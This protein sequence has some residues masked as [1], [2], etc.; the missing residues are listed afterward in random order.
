MEISQHLLHQLQCWPGSLISYKD[1]AY[2]LQLEFQFIPW[3]FHAW[4]IAIMFV[5]SYFFFF[6]LSKHYKTIQS[7]R[8]CF[9]S[10]W[11]ILAVHILFSSLLSS[12]MC[13]VTYEIKIGTSMYLCN[14]S[15]TTAFKKNS[16]LQLSE[17]SPVHLLS[18]YHSCYPNTP[19]FFCTLKIY[20]FHMF[21]CLKNFK[22]FI[23]LLISVPRD[24]LNWQLFAALQHILSPL[25]Q[26]TGCCNS[27]GF[28]QMSQCS[29]WKKMQQK[30][31]Y[32]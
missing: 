21:L 27:R 5:P 4:T 20:A 22:Y 1:S 25:K 23:L 28:P 18:L 3:L 32:I 2:I 10:H 14:H 13:S 6:F 17:Y 16:R 30:A 31:Q 29:H 24:Q 12:Y 15:R 11:S 9:V 7:F 19:S 8:A 26:C